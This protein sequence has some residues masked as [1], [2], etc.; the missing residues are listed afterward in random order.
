MANFIRSVNL[1]QIY[2]HKQN[3]KVFTEILKVIDI[4][5]TNIKSFNIR[6]SKSNLGKQKLL[7][8]IFRILQFLTKIIV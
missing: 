1:N 6:K 5:E 3:I 8:T 7:K 2:Y 4:F